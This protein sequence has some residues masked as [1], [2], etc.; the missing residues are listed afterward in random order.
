MFFKKRVVEPPGWLV[1]LDRKQKVYARKLAD[2]L[3]RKA[4]EMGPGRVKLY[5][6]GLVWL[7]MA[8]LICMMV[9]SRG[10]KDRMSLY[11]WP[12]ALILQKPKYPVMRES[13]HQ[14][15]DSLRRDRVFDSLIRARPGLED[16]LRFL[17]EMSES[18]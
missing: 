9:I 10:R 11:H 5:L 18:R 3:G 7:M 4:S 12:D 8:L 2:Y 15:V 1:E 13:F 14:Y 17:E 6:A 16:S